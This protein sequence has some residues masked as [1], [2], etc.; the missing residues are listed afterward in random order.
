MLHD[1]KDETFFK[2]PKSQGWCKN[3]Y[4]H[5]LFMIILENYLFSLMVEQK[6]LILSIICVVFEVSSFLS[7]LVPALGQDDWKRQ[8]AIA[9]FCAS[10]FSLVSINPEPLSWRLKNTVKQSVLWKGNCSVIYLFWGVGMTKQFR[11]LVMQ[12]FTFF[13]EAFTGGKLNS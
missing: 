8:T 1:I 2:P 5:S 13:I 9:E 4:C 11:I 3:E 12:I 7:W 10:A 6:C